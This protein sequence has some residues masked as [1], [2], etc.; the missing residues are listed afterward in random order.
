MLFAAQF[1]GFGSEVASVMICQYCSSL[2]CPPRCGMQPSVFSFVRGS[3]A[4]PEAIH[5]ED[6]DGCVVRSARRLVWRS[7]RGDRPTRKGWK[8]LA[9]FGG[10]VSGAWSSMWSVASISGVSSHVNHHESDRWRK[11]RILLKPATNSAPNQ[12]PEMSK[13]HWVV[14]VLPSSPNPTHCEPSGLTYLMLN[15]RHPTYK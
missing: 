14:R 10:R 15:V 12:P 1:L 6:L 2:A 9:P 7:V 13:T 8:N 11:V 3:P 5:Q 4:P